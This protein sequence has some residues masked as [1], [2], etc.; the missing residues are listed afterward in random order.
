MQ[1]VPVQKGHYNIYNIYF[2]ILYC[3]TTSC[4]PNEKNVVDPYALTSPKRKV[5][6]QSYGTLNV[7]N[8]LADLYGKIGLFYFIVSRKIN[9]VYVR[10]ICVCI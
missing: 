4:H 9:G 7:L 1:P 10:S 2:F 8:Y 3:L 5:H 6:C